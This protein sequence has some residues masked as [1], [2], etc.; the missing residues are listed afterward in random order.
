[1]VFELVASSLYI[2]SVECSC[3][4]VMETD[5]VHAGAIGHVL[6]GVRSVG[7]LEKEG[8]LIPWC[9]DNKAQIWFPVDCSSPKRRSGEAVTL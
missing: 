9:D 1:M 3:R 5:E 4:C 2:V 8:K 7:R 6:L